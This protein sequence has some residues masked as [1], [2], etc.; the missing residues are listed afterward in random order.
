MDINAQIICIGNEIML[1]HIANTNSQFISNR[2][3]AIGIKTSKHLD[4]PDNPEVIISSIKKALNESDIVILSGGL[5]PTVD[6][7]TL[8]C[9]ARALNKKLIF[10]KKIA[11]RIKAH[12]KRRKIRMPANNLRQA[13]LPEYA[14]PINNNIGTA[15]GLII[16]VK[17]KALIAFPGVPFEL[18]SMLEE[19][20]LPYLKKI[21]RPGQVIKSR[22]IKI[23][24]LAE[25]EVN[26][27]IEDILKISGNVQM[28]IYPHPEEIQVKITVTEKN[29]ITADSI[30][31]K[32]Q[33]KI[34]ARLKN[35]I[36]GYDNEKLEEI[37]GK[38]LSRSKKTLAIAESCTGGLLA[39]RITDIP[40]SSDYFKLGIITYSNESKNKLLDIPMETIKK[41]GAVSKEVA[42]LMAKNVRMLAGA[43]YGIG[44]SGILGPGGA[45]SRKPAGLVY[46]ALS[47]KAKTICKEF[48]FVGTRN[49]IKYKSTQAALNMLRLSSKL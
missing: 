26:E 34:V 22:V 25:S 12:F 13:L 48:C 37:V 30:I 7:L 11:G 5:G 32:I 49:L 8:E 19:T 21:F 35:Y 3:A 41:Y 2:L 31:N 16:P 4:I 38:T 6:D 44:I 36:F 29:E 24:G 42:G 43:D 17:D 1:G 47:T 45:T 15:P 20:A 33:K 46:I 27:I 40:G 14:I 39:D 9:I 18:Y 28:G 23:T 10:N